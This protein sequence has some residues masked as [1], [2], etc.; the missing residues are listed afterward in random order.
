[1]IAR[2]TVISLAVSQLVSWGVSFYLIGGFGAAIAAGLEW[3]LDSVHAGFALGLLVM[4]MASPLTG[5]LIDRYGGR[6][7]MTA[8]S[9]L[10]ALGCAALAATHGAAMYILAWLCLGLGMRL[11]LYDAA[12]AALARIGGPYARGP[13]AQITL[14]G[15]LAS[16][17]FW[18]LG[19][20]LADHFGWRGA[21]VAYA[22]FS[23]LTIP[24]YLA[25]P[26]VRHDGARP[27]SARPAPPPLAPHGARLKLAAGLYVLLTTLANFLNAGMSAHMIAILGGLGLGA[28]L[29]VWIATLRGVGQSLARFCEILSGGRLHPIVLNFHAC[30]L[31]PLAFVAALYAGASDAAAVVFAFL[32]GAC[33]G[34][35]TIT[36]GTLPLVLFDHRTYGTLVG[37]LIAPSFMFSA[38]APV[39]YAY[40]MEGRGEQWGVYLSLG[41]AL[42]ML[43]AALG[44]L[45]VFRRRDGRQ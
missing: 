14:L 7:A 17:V 13:M 8:G 32:Y 28:A 41:C 10:N 31:M 45:L 9:V 36:R 43:A 2:R 39:A 34:I 30:L 33:N 18:P 23:L 19:H 35:L 37:R 5:R 4:G 16:T 24:L 1:M 29:S 21:M 3:R 22:V 44:L 40:L 20:L 11:T 27:A 26:D 12:F 25:I 15:G 38:A 6:A 42:A